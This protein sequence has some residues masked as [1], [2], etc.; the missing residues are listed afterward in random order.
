MIDETHLRSK[1]WVI[2]W[3]CVLLPTVQTIGEL[4]CGDCSGRAEAYR[5]IGI[6]H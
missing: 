3:F 6:T 5:Q 2:E 4:C 1:L